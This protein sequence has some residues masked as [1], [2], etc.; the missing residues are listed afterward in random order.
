[1]AARRLGDGGVL[2]SW[3]VSDKAGN[4]LSM[5]SIDAFNAAWALGYQPVL[6]EGTTVQL[7]PG[8]IV[9][10]SSIHDRDM[11]WYSAEA[12]NSGLFSNAFI[13]RVLSLPEGWSISTKG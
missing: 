7:K 1:M 8:N 6:P 5:K 3:L 4:N 11:P 12:W 13:T 2:S 10:I 9:V